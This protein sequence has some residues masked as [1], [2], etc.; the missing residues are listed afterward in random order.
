VK[1]LL[2]ALAA[3]SALALAGCIDSAKPI[4]TDAKPVFGPHVK[5]QFYGLYK[6]AAV[7]PEQADYVWKDGRYVHAGGGMKDTAAFSVHPF[8]GD[9]SIIQSV[10]ADK[11]RHFDY[12]V[13]HKL[14]DGVYH[15]LPIDENDASEAVRKANCRKTKGSPCRVETR[16]QLFAL[17]RATAAKRHADRGGLAI[18]RPHK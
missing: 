8:A 3:L 2:A 11:E 16:E 18:R 13:M 14:L 4:L 6:G 15:V 5:F 17:A 10:P 7:D 1:R 12:A 9:N